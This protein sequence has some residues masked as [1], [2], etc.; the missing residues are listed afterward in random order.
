M[1]Q[2]QINVHDTCDR[3]ETNKMKPF[4]VPTWCTCDWDSEFLCYPD[5]GECV[6][7]VWK[8]HVHC[9]KCGGISQVG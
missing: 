8:H 9:K 5:D 2:I 4:L 1:K 7:G 6:C 3:K